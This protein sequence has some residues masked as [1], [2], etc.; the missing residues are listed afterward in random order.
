MYYKVI[1]NGKVIDVLDGIQYVRWYPKHNGIVSTVRKF[2]QGILSSDQN[3][4]WH[5]N[6]LQEFSISG[7]DAVDVV[8]IDE[9]E[10]RRLR[11]LNLRTPEEIIDEFVLSLIED[12]LL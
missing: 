12:G 2:A 8:R 4:I 7:Y 11:V 10:Y 3:T 1:K 5:V 6:G 9:S